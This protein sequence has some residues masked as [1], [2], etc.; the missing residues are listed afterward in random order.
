[1]RSIAAGGRSI[2]GGQVPVGCVFVLE[3]C[4]AEL[5]AVDD[6]LETMD[7]TALRECELFVTVGPCIMC[8]SALATL[9]ACLCFTSARSLTVRRGEVCVLRLS[10]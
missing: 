1:M 3:A 9:C 10:E 6:V 5:V 7:V 2:G 4:N 8:T